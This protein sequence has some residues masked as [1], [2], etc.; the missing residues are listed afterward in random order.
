[1]LLSRYFLVPLYY[2]EARSDSGKYDN[3]SSLSGGLGDRVQGPK[4]IGRNGKAGLYKYDNG[5][6]VKMHAFF[7]LCTKPRLQA[8]R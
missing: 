2:E 8:G 3:A 5:E 7:F 1:M 4:T 6:G